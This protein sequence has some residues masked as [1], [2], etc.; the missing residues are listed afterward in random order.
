MHRQNL[1]GSLWM[2]ASMG[3][4]ALEDTFVKVVTKT[5]PIGE[6]F[7]LFGL[8]GMLIYT[9]LL[10]LNREPLYIPDVSSRPMLIRVCFE[11]T[12]RRIRRVFPVFLFRGCHPS[13][14]THPSPLFPEEKYIETTDAT[15]AGPCAIWTCR[16]SI[17]EFGAGSQS[18]DPRGKPN[19]PR[20]PRP[21]SAWA[22]NLGF[23][24]RLIRD[25]LESK[26]S[27]V[28]AYNVLGKANYSAL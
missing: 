1:V 9:A 23:E 10:Y 24:I 8:G 6:V 4:F 7:I 11:V 3:A 5:V 13:T 16:A 21:S 28:F 14:L 22:T 17:V 25:N 20:T 26:E 2:I 18:A 15:D 19:D 12:G 27:L